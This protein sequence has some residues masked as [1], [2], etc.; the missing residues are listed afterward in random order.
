[1]KGSKKK[2]S[3][4]LAIII[5][6]QV[7][8]LVY[9]G[10]QKKDYHIDEIYSYIL[11][12]SYDTDRISHADWMW[13][14]WI[15]GES[16]QDFITVQEGEEFAYSTVYRNNSMD[17]HPP[18]FYWILHTMCSFMPDSFSKWTG[19][20]INIILFVIS[21]IFIYLISD[22]LIKSWKW[23][24]IPIVMWGFSSFAVD[25]CT[26]IRMYMLLTT[27]TVCFVYLHIKMFRYGITVSRM[28]AVWGVI[29][30]GG[31]THYYS[32]LVS[33]PGV[34]FFSLYLLRKK[35]IKAMFTYGIGACISVGVM[36]LS[37]PY[38]FEQVTGSST[39]NVGNQIAKNLFNFPLW[40]DQLKNLTKNLLK[41]ISYHKIISLLI[42]LTFIVLLLIMIVLNIKDKSISSIVLD[43]KEIFWII[44][45]FIFSF[46]S[47]SFIGGEYVY[48]RYIYYIVPLIY[49]IA[50]IVLEK[51][52]QGKTFLSNAIRII[53][54]FFAISNAAYGTSRNYSSYL[55]RY[56][57]NC[58]EKIEGYSDKSLYV[59]SEKVS[60]A[61]STGNLT[62]FELFDK[63]YMAPKDN[64]IEN[65]MIS[66][67]I[68]EQGACVVYIATDSYWLNGFDPDKVLNEALL[69]CNAEYEYITDGTLGKFYYIHK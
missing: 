20:L 25:T 14:N 24:F 68:Q 27:I 58:K 44:G 6:V 31:M 54:I 52:L 61:V 41:N 66:N 59:I 50:V 53:A 57:S 19:L 1:M 17:C 10:F 55:Y 32:L 34:L 36:I 62:I 47:I 40:I 45:I 30:L 3:I 23:K 37:Y 8:M 69:Y 4:I 48:L 60:S 15:S 18:L 67:T 11:S 35:E 51:L 26:F 28:L 46:L 13:N 56:K 43:L 63:I 64:I 2:Q 42:G 39:N 9:V 7:L 5:A 38:I 29:Y 22:E 49:L 65:D 12:N 21:G 16:F 33:F